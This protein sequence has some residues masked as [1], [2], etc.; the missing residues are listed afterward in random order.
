MECPDRPALKILDTVMAQHLDESPDF[1]SF[2]PTDPLHPHPVWSD[3]TDPPSPFA[4]L[5]RRAFALKHDPLEA[6]LMTEAFQTDDKAS[7]ARSDAVRARL[8]AEVV[9]KFAV[10]YKL[11]SS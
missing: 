3:D 7:C 11:W 5:L 6:A 8:Q 4:E 1:E 10:R 9:D 2:D